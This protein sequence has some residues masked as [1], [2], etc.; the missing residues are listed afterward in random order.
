M[1]NDP[2]LHLWYFGAGQYRFPAMIGVS[3]ITMW[4]ITAIVFFIPL[5]PGER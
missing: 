5:R 4:I 1:A 2:V 3:A